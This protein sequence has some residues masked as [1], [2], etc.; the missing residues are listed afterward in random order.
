MAGRARFTPV[1]AAGLAVVA[2]ALI[3]VPAVFLGAGTDF[4]GRDHAVPDD[5]TMASDGLRDEQVPLELLGA[6]G[7]LPKVATLRPEMV[8]SLTDLGAAYQATVAQAQ[9]SIPLLV[10]D[11]YRRA[12]LILAQRIPGCGLQWPLLAGVGRVVSDHAGG[13]DLDPQGTTAGPILGPRLDGTPGRAKIADTDD[14]RLDGDQA[15]DRA[16]GPM[17]IIP[18]V[19]QR[20]GADSNGDG[21]ASPHSVYDAALVAGRFLCEGGV[22]LR[23]PGQQVRAAFR[24]Q[25][26]ETF[27]RAVI[28]WAR[29]YGAGLA[30]PTAPVP[31]PVLPDPETVTLPD[32]APPPG[33]LPPGRA[34]A[35][36]ASLAGPAPAGAPPAPS[37]LVRD[38]RTTTPDPTPTG[39]NPSLTETTTPDP[40]PSK[41]HPSLTKTTTPSPHRPKTTTPEF[42]PAE[43]L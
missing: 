16:A 36:A 41:T 37:P 5:G 38:G 2:A 25:R 24:Y 13:G 14:G 31:L 9:A 7:V 4:R 23:A 17:Q 28:L 27:V 39:S 6:S 26:S 12:E 32:E 35:P 15:W 43:P 22:D 29:A 34:R 18:P 8:S 30:P 1:R 42:T 11:A 3:G 40:T 20:L 19:W 33:P 10:L 21:A